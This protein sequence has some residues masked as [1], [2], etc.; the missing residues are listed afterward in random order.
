M[1]RVGIIGM[2]RV[3]D[4][5]IE[6]VRHL[7]EIEVVCVSDVDEKKRV[8]TPSG[9]R[10]YRNFHRMLLTERPDAVFVLVPNLLHYEISKIV[11]EEGI[12]LLVEKPATLNMQELKNLAG[13][14]KEKDLVFVV[15]LHY[16][17]AKEVLWFF[18]RYSRYM[19]KELGKIKYFRCDF[20]D[21]YIENS[22]LKEFAKSLNGSWIDSG[23]NALSVLD[24]FVEDISLEES[25]LVH[26]ENINRY[27][28]IQSDVFLKGCSYR[29]IISTNWALEINCKKTSFY[30][31]N[32][33]KEIVL[34]HS[35]QQVL[36]KEDE[37]TQIIADFSKTGDRLVNHYIGVLR[38]FVKHFKNRTDNT[39]KAIYLHGILFEALEKNGDINSC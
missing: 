22:R 27:G 11:I 21:P 15:A 24:L 12:N 2:G 7:N 30:F 14:A 16:R 37:C 4:Y 32:E 34:N 26:I 23:I 38:D 5:Y 13:T 29:G 35:K 20:F 6:A 3:F 1:I 33:K 10:F 9:A 17:F 8:K 28:D 31:E 18:D 19:E 25:R 39:Q 36:L